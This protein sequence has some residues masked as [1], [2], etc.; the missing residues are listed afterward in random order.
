MLEEAIAV[1]RQ[2][3]ANVPDNEGLIRKVTDKLCQTYENPP[4]K[5][6]EVVIQKPFTTD[7]VRTALF[8]PLEDQIPYYSSLL[9][10]SVEAPIGHPLIKTGSLLLTLIYLIHR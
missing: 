3:F 2:E 7:E 10:A 5:D 8:A 9:L 4:V 1:V 6:F